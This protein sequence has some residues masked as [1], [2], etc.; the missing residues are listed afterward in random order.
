MEIKTPSDEVTEAIESAIAWFQ[1]SAIK[2]IRIESFPIDPV[3]D[4]NKTISSDK[5]VVK[6]P[7]AEPTWARFYEIDT[8]RPF[9]C[10]RDGI[11]VYSLD[12]VK[13][14]RRTGYSWYGGYATSLLAEDYLK[15]KKR[16]NR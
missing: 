14:E 16:L 7:N 5:R 3:K 2:G 10:N 6:D 15:W 1:K 8:N 12:K 11:K 4:L 9:F 13:L